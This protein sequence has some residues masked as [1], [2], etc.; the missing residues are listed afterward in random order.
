MYFLVF[1]YLIA[2]G[3]FDSRC[4]IV[5]ATKKAF[6]HTIEHENNIHHPSAVC[7]GGPFVNQSVSNLT[8]YFPTLYTV[9]IDRILILLT[10]FILTFFYPGKAPISLRVRWYERQILPNFANQ[11]KAQL[12]R[13]LRLDFSP[14]NAYTLL[15]NHL[16][17]CRSFLTSLITCS[18]YSF[19]SSPIRED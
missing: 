13:L 12:N 9:S 17:T 8:Q 2:S 10:L 18:K 11:D 15:M 16:S 3:V 5:T 1:F 6:M 19:M 4:T 14:C 7:N